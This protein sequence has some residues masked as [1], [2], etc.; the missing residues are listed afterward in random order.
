MSIIIPIYNPDYEAFVRCWES[1]KEFR[2][3]TEY[4]FVD[5]GSKIGI[6]A[7][8]ELTEFDK[9]VI[10]IRKE[11]G[12]V[13]SARNAGIARASGRYLFFV[14]ADDELSPD[15][16]DMLNSQAFNYDDEWIIFDMVY[17]DIHKGTRKVRKTFPDIPENV[18]D[19]VD[20]NIEKALHVRTSTPRLNESCGKLISL[21]FILKYKISFPQGILTGEDAVFNTEILRHVSTIRY[22]PFVAYI[23]WFDS[24]HYDQRLWSE[25][26]KIIESLNEK[27]YQ[28][29]KV[30]EERVAS[31]NRDNYIRQINVNKIINLGRIGLKLAQKN[32]LNENTKKIIMESCNN[33]ACLDEVSLNEFVGL[34]NK[35]FY[36]TM[37][38]RLWYIIKIFAKV[39]G[40]NLNL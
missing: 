38:Y 16:I 32:I 4:I 33:S 12:G 24:A 1:I 20:I 5:D 2:I 39:C 31:G 26:L 36:I 7:C 9:R 18:A 13:S 29:R 27:S 28:A 22:V 14:D 10:W 37:K 21:P 11:N 30:I 25:P 34:K 8:I 17:Y 6:D 35:I 40:Q 3:S 15:F 19:G 23:Y